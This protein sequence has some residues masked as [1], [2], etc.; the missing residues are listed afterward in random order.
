LR[1]IVPEKPNIK[2]GEVNSNAN[3]IEGEY[4]SSHVEDFIHVYYSFIAI[5]FAVCV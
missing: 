2:Q 1:A 4:S 3:E 5:Y